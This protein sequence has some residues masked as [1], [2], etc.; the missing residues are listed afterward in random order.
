M[1]RLEKRL[2]VVD[3]LVKGQQRVVTDL[4]RRGTETEVRRQLAEN[5]PAAAAVVSG[6]GSYVRVLPK[7]TVMDTSGN[8]GAAFGSPIAVSLAA[9][10]PAGKSRA[11]CELTMRS[12]RSGGDANDSDLEVQW[13]IVGD[14][15]WTVLKKG[16]DVHELVDDATVHVIAQVFLPLGGL[17][18]GEVQVMETDDDWFYTLNLIGYD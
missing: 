16:F 1:A 6:G 8:G 15:E 9:W 11:W 18:A 10:V 17:Q 13:R 12:D 5:A 14:P 4:A 7:Q 3:G 2:A